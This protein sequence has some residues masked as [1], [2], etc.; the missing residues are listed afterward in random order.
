MYKK[1]RE[2]GS[3]SKTVEFV[4]LARYVFAFIPKK[5]E[6][7]DPV[8]NYGASEVNLWWFPLILVIYVNIKILYVIN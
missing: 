4:L 2:I 8:V 3:F 5:S 1:Y 6:P 7:L